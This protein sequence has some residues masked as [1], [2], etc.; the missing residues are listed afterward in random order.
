MG[1]AVVQAFN[2]IGVGT[3]QIRATIKHPS[4]LNPLIN[5]IMTIT[6]RHP[7]PN[8]KVGRASLPVELIL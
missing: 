8:G 7:G 5:F 4:F 6:Q 3:V 2:N 1:Q